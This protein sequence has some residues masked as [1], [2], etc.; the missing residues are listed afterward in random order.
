MCLHVTLRFSFKSTTTWQCGNNAIG[1][2]GDVQPSSAARSYTHWNALWISNSQSHL[3][4]A[5]KGDRQ[6]GVR[7]LTVTF[8][9]QYS[10]ALTFYKDL[11]VSEQ[12]LVSG[13]GQGGQQHQISKT[14]ARRTCSAVCKVCKRGGPRSGA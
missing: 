4:T 11:N 8:R 5:K 12:L 13:C 6:T 14:A 7:H 9:V 2:S 1:V 10:S 3:C